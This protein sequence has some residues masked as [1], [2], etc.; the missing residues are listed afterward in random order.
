VPEQSVDNELEQA[1]KSKRGSILQLCEEIAGE[2]E[3]DTVEVKKESQVESV[4]EEKLTEIKLEETDVEKQMLHQK[5]TN[6]DVQCNRFF[7]SRKTKPV[8]CILNGINSSTKKNSNWTKI[9]LS[10]FNSVQQ[11]KL[12]SQVS[13]KLG[14][15]RTSFSSPVLEM[16]HPVTQSTFLDT[17]SL[18][19][20]MTCQQEKMKE[21]KPEEV[22]INDIT[23]ETSK[24]SKR[25]PENCH[26]DNQI[27]PSSDPPL[28]NQMKHSFESTADKVISFHCAQ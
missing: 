23:V 22:K 13:P 19:K 1:G 21:I 15:L 16:H 27:K 11:N 26:L 3:S 18:D 14:L 10:K 5:G 9:K 8:K 20:N 24:I 25:A 28:D 7:P 6:Q 17:K 12:D 2:I 4:K